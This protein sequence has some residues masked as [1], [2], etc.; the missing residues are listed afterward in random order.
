MQRLDD[1]ALRQQAVLAVATIW[2][3]VTI[4]FVALAMPAVRKHLT[5]LMTPVRF[6]ER[7]QWSLALAF[8]L[9]WTFG[10]HP[11]L[12]SFPVMA[13][14]PQTANWFQYYTTDPAVPSY[15]FLGMFVAISTVWVIGPLAEELIFRGVI[16]GSL[17][18]RYSVTRAVLISSAVFAAMHYASC[19]FAFGIGI[20]YA[21]MAVRYGSLWPGI[22]LHCLGNSVGTI[23]YVAPFFK[24]KSAESIHSLDGWRF[25]FA[26]ALLSLPVLFL[27]VRALRQPVKS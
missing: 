13:A 1:R 7:V 9:L 14:W 11:M 25:E 22:A 18:E 27:L 5:R 23:P 6:P 15:S 21:A 24:N 19:V 4:S 3:L 8:I 12:V 10:L 20:V 2:S 26:L 17:L 16:M